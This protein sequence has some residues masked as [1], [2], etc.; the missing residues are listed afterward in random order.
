[1]NPSYEN[2]SLTN[3]GIDRRGF[4]KGIEASGALIL[5]ANWTWSQEEEKKYGEPY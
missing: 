2:F 3:H 1:M 5:T 4:I